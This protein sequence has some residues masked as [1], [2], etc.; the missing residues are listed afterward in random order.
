[1]SPIQTIEDKDERTSLLCGTHNRTTQKT[2]KK[3]EQHGPHQKPGGEL[4]AR[5]SV[6]SIFD[7]PFGVL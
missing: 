2:I 4:R 6:L 5:F 7:C 1:M 3:N